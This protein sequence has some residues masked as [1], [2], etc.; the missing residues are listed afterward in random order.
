MPVK[1]RTTYLNKGRF[2]DRR[3]RADP[4]FRHVERPQATVTNIRLGTSVG[5]GHEPMAAGL[6]T[7]Q[8]ISCIETW[9][10]IYSS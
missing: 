4:S 7:A 9:I 3:N 6:Q 5:S 1:C 10:L 8:T 2:K